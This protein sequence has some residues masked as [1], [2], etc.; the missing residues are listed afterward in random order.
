LA[1]AAIELRYLAASVFHLPGSG[2]PDNE[3]VS[4]IR[5]AFRAV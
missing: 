5:K 1:P 3:L 4:R 2:E